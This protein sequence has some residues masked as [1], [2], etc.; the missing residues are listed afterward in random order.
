M[1]TTESVALLWNNRHELA[2]P[3]KRKRLARFYRTFAELIHS[4]AEGTLYSLEAMQSSP[5]WEHLRP[6]YRRWLEEPDAENT[7]EEMRSA[8]Q[9]SID[10]FYSVKDNKIRDPLVMYMESGNRHLILGYRRLVIANVLGID[11]VRVLTHADYETYST[12]R[13]KDGRSSVGSLEF[14]T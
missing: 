8:F 6:K 12:W 7:V 11:A 13:C 4:I 9:T 10:L 2:Q 3:N 1:D 5:W 14:D